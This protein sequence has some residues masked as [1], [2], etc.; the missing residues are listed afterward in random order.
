MP[1]V[2]ADTFKRKDKVVAAVAMPGIPEG[3]PGRVTM[4]AGFDWIRYWVYFENG[5]SRGSLNRSKLA[6]ASDWE[7]IKRRREAGEDDHPGAADGS[8]GDAGGAGDGAAAGSSEGYMHNGVLVPQLL[9]D[10]SKKRREIL[11]V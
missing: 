6:R 5:V 4:V 1:T 7:E 10:R 9:L 2:Q 3:T 11:G 8:D